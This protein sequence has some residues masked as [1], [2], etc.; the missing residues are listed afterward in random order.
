MRCLPKTSDPRLLVGP[1]TYDDAAVIKLDAATAIVQTVDFFTP[2]V[3]DPYAFG[4]IAAANALSDIYAM[5]AEPLSAMNIIAFPTCLGTDALSQVL[6]GGQSKVA[7]A[8]AILVGGHSIEDKEPKYGLAVTG[9]IDP[10]QVIT[11][12]GAKPG[13]KLILTKPL[14]TGIVAT[15]SK[16]NL[17]TPSEVER[18]VAVMTTLNKTAAA[19]MREAGANACTDVTGFGLL[20][21]A[22]E[23]AAASG[24]GLRLEAAQIPMLAAARVYAAMGI[25]PAGAYANRDYLAEQVRFAAAVD[26]TLQ[27]ILFDPQT[28]GG[29]LISLPAAAA[30]AALAR[31]REQGTEAAIIGEVIAG[32]PGTISVE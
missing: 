27:D 32:E 5:G 25:V 12:A 28:S 26:T 13:D 31:L 3:D 11:N 22:H 7:E 19:V 29:L 8:G 20:G 23:L 30:A 21:H 14:G 10:N 17:A 1:E 18:M 16:G 24:A 6:L 15:A 4:Q 9:L 2:I